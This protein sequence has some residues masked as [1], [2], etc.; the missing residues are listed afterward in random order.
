MRFL[1]VVTLV[2]ATSACDRGD[3][4]SSRGDST[5]V[6]PS[7]PALESGVSTVAA[8][9]AT[10]C[11]G[12]CGGSCGGGQCNGSCGGGT[13]AAADPVEVPADAVWTELQVTGMK[14]G[15]CARRIKGALARLDGV[16]GVEVDLAAARVRVATAAGID[17]R[18]VAQPAI[19]ALGYRV[20]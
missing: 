12:A 11:G 16:V 13:V 1:L 2:L 19:D 15:G 17:G 20:Q 6:A 9:P 5:A 7:R 8:P 14:C 4:T 3:A 18:G 10:S